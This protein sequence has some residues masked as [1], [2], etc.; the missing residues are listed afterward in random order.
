M[1]KLKLYYCKL[2]FQ[3]IS[4]ILKLNSDAAGR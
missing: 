4:C 2:D 3:L 1:L